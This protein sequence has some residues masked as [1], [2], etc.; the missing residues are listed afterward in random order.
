MLK[1][2]S[3]LGKK[4][5]NVSEE[6]TVDV[7]ERIIGT[8]TDDG[9]GVD[10]IGI[11]RKELLLAN[12]QAFED[13]AGVLWLYAGGNPVIDLMNI[14]LICGIICAT[15]LPDESRSKVITM[16]GKFAIDGELS[17]DEIGDLC[18]MY[19]VAVGDV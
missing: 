10:A 15:E 14:K 16:L 6:T 9:C 11:V 3:V 17:P 19:D 12:D 5:E 8:M 18:E 4:G 13:E 1:S 7:L 2:I